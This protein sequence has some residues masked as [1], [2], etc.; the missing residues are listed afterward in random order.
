M[1][2]LR[3]YITFLLIAACSSSQ[4]LRQQ[5]DRL[6]VLMGGAANPD[7]FS[8]AP[9]AAAFARE[10]NMIE[11]ENVMKFGL[12]H[13]A[14]SRY[15][16]AAADRIVS[17]AQANG[18]KVRGHT[19]VWHQQVPAWVT[20]GNFSSDQLSA[21]LH[22]HISTVLGH[23]AGQVFAWDVVN[24]A[25]NDGPPTLRST[26]WSD[27]PGIGFKGQGTQYIEQAFRWAHEADPN[28]LL[29]YNDYNA[30]VVNA[31]SDAVYAMVKDFKTRGVPIDGVGLQM[32]LSLS[33]NLTRLGENIQRLID[34]GLQVHITELDVSIPVNPDGTPVDPA[35]L[36]KQAQVYRDVTATCLRYRGC[37]AIQTWGLTDKYSWIPG[38]TQNKNG[39]AL[40]LDVNYQPKP[41]YDSMVDAFKNAAVLG[42]AGASPFDAISATSGTTLIAPDSLVSIFGSGL[43]AS[44]E[45][46]TTDP[47]PTTLGGVTLQVTDSVGAQ[48]LAPLLFVSPGQ[49]NCL[50]PAATAPGLATLT[51][52]GPATMSGTA[53]IQPLAPALFA[54]NA[55]GRGVAAASAIRTVIPTSI[56]SPVTVYRCGNTAGSCVAVPIDTPVTLTLFGSGIRRR[57]SLDSVHVSIGGKIIPALYAGPQPQFAGL[58]QINVPLTLDL[59]GRG[60]VDVQVEI[61]GRVSNTVQIAL[62]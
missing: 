4:A 58:D 7:K 50:I 53:L 25:F 55:N 19:L 26:L 13:P 59:R 10:L 28:T 47:L 21:I 54:A 24:E 44:T 42:H 45:S 29:F 22:D 5:A 33:P 20:N 3:F 11:P 6:G 36:Q 2:S 52:N 16:W 46:A 17:F 23:Y 32:H 51:I 31:K 12:I 38:F 15:D 39:L 30:E 34:L 18:M 61:D 40:P 37:S 35:A 1:A 49:I 27:T 56:Q 8:E 57:A 43:A 14:S 60:L 62:Q 41:A 9:Y 48:R